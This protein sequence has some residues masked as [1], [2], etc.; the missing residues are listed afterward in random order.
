MPM[1]P[2]NVGSVGS[3]GSDRRAARTTRSTLNGPALVQV[4]KSR[5]L[6]QRFQAENRRVLQDAG[7]SCPQS[8]IERMT[9]A[10]FSQFKNSALDDR[11]H[12]TNRFHLR[13][14]H[15]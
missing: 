11:F 15:R 4:Q 14:F 8:A 13:I 3:T 7:K 6:Q 12:E 9:L 5:L 2:E 10:G 1:A